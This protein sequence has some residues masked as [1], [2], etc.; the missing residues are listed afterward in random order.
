MCTVAH[1]NLSLSDDRGGFNE[2]VDKLCIII[3][4]IIIITHTH[5]HTHT[6]TH[7][8]TYR[9]GHQMH[10][11]LAISTFSFLWNYVSGLDLVDTFL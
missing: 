10:P 9:L 3:I 2:T 5:A 11:Q 7:T 6:H 8:H 4:I 1:L